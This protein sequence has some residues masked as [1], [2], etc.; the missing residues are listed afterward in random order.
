MAQFAN[1]QHAV[2]AVQD[3]LNSPYGTHIREF[4]NIYLS[5]HASSDSLTAFSVQNA[6]NYWTTKVSIFLEAVS[7]RC[8]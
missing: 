2:N 6:L 1:V 3:I 4:E 5:S 8:D 7:E